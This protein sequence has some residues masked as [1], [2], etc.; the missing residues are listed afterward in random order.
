MFRMRQTDA[1]KPLFRN[2]YADEWVGI[3]VLIA[4]VLFVGAIIE[5]GFLKKWLTPE[6][7]IHFVLPQSGVAGL[8][9]GDD[10]EVMGVH[11]GE[12]RHLDLNAEGRMYAEGSIEPQ[13]KPFVRT[14]STAIIR[15]RFVVA[16]ASYIELGR[17]RAETLDW[18]YAVLNASVEPN[19]A[20]VITQTVT[21]L[22]KQLV[23]AMQNVTAITGQVNAMVTD[24][25]AGKG[26]V[27][28]LLTKD[29]V[30]RQANQALETLNATIARIQPI[31]QQLSGAMTK[32]DGALDNARS[33][34]ATLRKTM[35]QVQQ[36]VI[37]ANTAT[38]QLPALITQAEASA[39]SLRQLTDQLKGLW[40]LGGGGA[41][42]PE[43]RLPAQ[44]VRP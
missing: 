22:R 38:A 23:P 31:E 7:K 39:S 21:D 19:P 33:A 24:M 1:A 18:K 41:Q 29:D 15:H 3:V 13:F 42:K 12:I 25:R 14:D 11:A 35:P 28:A 26:T 17:G 20:D 16:G 44:A 27:G 4:L 30:I 34:T 6:A 36:T 32:A 8:A 5:A 2:R 43:R 37:H 40:L 10:I 9:I